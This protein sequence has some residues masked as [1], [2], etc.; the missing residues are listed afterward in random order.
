MQ[1]TGKRSIFIMFWT[2]LLIIL[3]SMAISTAIGARAVDYEIILTDPAEDS[4]AVFGD[5]ATTL[6]DADIIQVTSI[7]SGEN[8]V[9]TMKVTGSVYPQG[10]SYSNTQYTFNIDINGDLEMDWYVS[11]SNFLLIMGNDT[12]IQD[13]NNN[14][15]TY[16]PNATGSGTNTLTVTFPISLIAAQEIIY[17]WAIY[18]TTSLSGGSTMATD[19]APDDGFPEDE[20]ADNDGD[21]IP[22]YWE[23]K[24]NFDPNNASDAAEDA[25]GDGYTNK[26]EYDA[27]TGPYDKCDKPGG[28]ALTITIL[29]PKENEQ[30]PPGGIGSYYLMKGTT[31]A[32]YGDPIDR[33]EF[34]NPDA[35]VSDWENCYDNNTPCQDYSEWYAEISTETIMGTCAHFNKGKNTIEVRAFTESDENLT[36]KVTVYF[37]EEVPEDDT[38]SDGMPDD[39]EDANGLDKNDFSDGTKDA[40]GD[41]Y[42]NLAEYEAGTD[43]QDPNDYP[44]SGT[45]TDTDGDNTPDDTDTD[46]DNDGMPDTWEN[47]YGLKPKDPTDAAKD[48][49]K[50][51]YTNKEEFEAGTDP[52]DAKSYPGAGAEDDKDGDGMDDIW[53]VNYGLDPNDPSDKDQDMDNDGFTNYE[54][55]YYDTDPSDSSDHP[56][57]NGE[58]NDPAKAT[59]TDTGIQVSIETVSYKYKEEGNNITY[60]FYIKGTT[61]GADHCQIAIVSYYKDGSI[62]D[63]EWISPFNWEE[64]A[65]VKQEMANMGYT[66]WYFK[67][68]TANW[69]AWEFKI[70]GRFKISSNLGEDYQD[71]NENST[72]MKK[73]MVYVRAYSDPSETQWNQASHQIPGIGKSA[74]ENKDEGKGFLPGFE[75]ITLLSAL[76][77]AFVLLKRRR[78]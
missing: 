13:D 41:S 73:V 10:G 22:N 5:D 47:K 7:K 38:D 24:Y 78:Y 60:E 28:E 30:I 31:T 6:K 44:G 26:E 45:G 76:G 43:P 1:M 34:R 71:F 17:S 27:G 2:V 33:M 48:K 25:D 50:D 36:V 57:T 66:A 20:E 70:S 14:Y 23:A 68:T 72:N 67:A 29:K 11:T 56:T 51:G 75:V 8:I 19:S 65:Y 58:D 37:N 3:S 12:N 42:T 15:L 74:G 16:L 69:N 61:G 49:D 4:V 39:Y 62:D 77:V 35:L 40:D 59:P 52:T 9:L 53:E 63:V 18:G 64:N 32:I 55:F 21:G 54:E 46:D